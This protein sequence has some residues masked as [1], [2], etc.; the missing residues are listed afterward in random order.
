[1]LQ[2]DKKQIHR[3][4][5]VQ[6]CPSLLVERFV[7]G[8]HGETVYSLAAAKNVHADHPLQIPTSRVF[9]DILGLLHAVAKLPHDHML[10]AATPVDA[11][12]AALTYSRST[13][14][15]AVRWLRLLG[16]L[17]PLP[18]RRGRYELAPTA[19]FLLGLGRTSP[20]THDTN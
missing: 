19:R 1:M 11:I 14:F 9:A 5:M 8:R 7:F 10:L 12:V 17:R 13:I 16:F 2:H 15:L 6:P 20:V 4:D 3:D 18:H